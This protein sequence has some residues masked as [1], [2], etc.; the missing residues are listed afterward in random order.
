[1]KL[2]KKKETPV[3][4]R[5]YWQWSETETLHAEK[6]LLHMHRVGEPGRRHVVTSIHASYT[7]PVIGFMTLQH[8]MNVE[9][10]WYVH[11]QRDVS[12]P[13]V[14]PEGVDL[15]VSLNGAYPNGWENTTPALTVVGYTEDV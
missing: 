10:R 15:R 13:F 11:S 6:L 1:M 2:F 9:G 12:G 14:L 8:N 5:N 3:K 4:T 7:A